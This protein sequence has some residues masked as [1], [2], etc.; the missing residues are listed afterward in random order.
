[1]RQTHL[2]KLVTY[3]GE[4]EGTSAATELKKLLHIE[5]VRNTAK[6][7]G[8]YFKEKRKGMIDHI[9]IP[10]FDVDDVPTLMFFLLIPSWLQAVGQQHGEI[11][12]RAYLGVA[13][14][15]RCVGWWL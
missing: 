1:M 13:I 7:H 15:L 4:T 3:K 14:F 6:K 10:K 5:Q 8:W 11:V 9:L 12:F 2:E